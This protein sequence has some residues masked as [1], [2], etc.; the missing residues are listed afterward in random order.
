MFYRCESLI[1]VNLNFDTSKKFENEIKDEKT[2]D[3]KVV[4]FHQ[5][6]I[7]LL[8]LVYYYHLAL[9]LSITSMIV[10]FSL[11]KCKI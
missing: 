9:S 8:I 3:K 4:N 5:P 11:L 7:S 6:F 1:S 2:M 10:G